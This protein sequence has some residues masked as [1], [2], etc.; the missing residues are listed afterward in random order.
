MLVKSKPI[1]ESN[2][3]SPRQTE[4][5]WSSLCQKKSE[6]PSRYD[7]ADDI[8]RCEGSDFAQELRLDVRRVRWSLVFGY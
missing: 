1:P 4:T 2:N 8:N 5:D 3:A 6:K 7:A